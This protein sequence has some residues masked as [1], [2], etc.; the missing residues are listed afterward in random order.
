MNKPVSF[1]TTRSDYYYNR[2]NKIGV[3]KADYLKECVELG[4]SIFKSQNKY[5]W[6]YLTTLKKNKELINNFK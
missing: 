1:R 2:A 3:K 4:D 5:S 6:K